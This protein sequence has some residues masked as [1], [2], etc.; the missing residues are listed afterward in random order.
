MPTSKQRLVMTLASA[1]V[2]AN[3]VTVTGPTSATIV[4]YTADDKDPQ[5]NPMG[6]PT[7]SQMDAGAAVLA[8]FDWSDAA[9]QA[10]QAALSRPLAVSQLGL[11]NAQFMLLR[12]VVSVLVDEVNALRDWIT[13]FKTATAA[14][15]SLANLQTRVAGLAAMPDRTLS[16]ARTAIANAINA[17]TVDS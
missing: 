11:T 16:Q 17:G 2:P 5:G 13:S 7:Q 10:Y 15:T 3:G 9:E 14:A 6:P 12:G 8:A 1:G 4:Y